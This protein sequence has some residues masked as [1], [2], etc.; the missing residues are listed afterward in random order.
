MLSKDSAVFPYEQEAWNRVGTQPQ[1]SLSAAQQGPRWEVIAL[2]LTCLLL[3]AIRWRL[4]DMP[5]ERDEGEYAYAGQLMLQGIPPYQMAYNMKLPG[6]YAAYASIMAIAGQTDSGVRLGLMF[7]NLLTIFAVYGIGKR[8][9]GSKAGSVAAISYGL[10]SIGPWVHGFA[11]HATHFVVLFA[12]IGTLTLLHA[13]E[14]QRLWEI[15]AAGLLFGVAFLMK[16]PGAAF[17]LF[18]V[19]YLAQRS[20]W[21]GGGFS[22]SARR[23]AVL[24]LGMVLPFVLTC[25]LLWHAG[26]FA[27]F[28]FWTFSYAYQYGTNLGWRGG[29][30]FFSRNFTK[31]ALSA[32][33]LWTLAGIGI[34]SFLWDR[35]AR[36]CA[37][38][39]LGLLFFS[40]IALSAGLYFRPH[41]FI[42]LLPSISLLV[43]LAVN[44]AA[45]FFPHDSIL[46]RC[47]PA[48]AFSIACAATLAEEAKFFFQADPISAS[49][50]VY[51]EDP[52]PECRAIGLYIQRNLPP[53]ATMAMFGSEPQIMFYARR[54][55]V[56]GYLYGY[57]LTEEQK[58]ASI[59][60]RELIGEIESARPD[61]IVQV[62]DWD[63]RPGTDRSVFAWF[64]QYI[65]E[66]Y[67]ML[68]VLRKNDDLQ[69][70]PEDEIRR[71]PGNLEGAILLYVRRRF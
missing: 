18:A 7:V 21:L 25:A 60:Q 44:S 33:P 29:W 61:L 56:T 30:R 52:F 43:G 2:V 63:L 6:T 32:I 62:E 28:W 41:Y 57:S 12:I 14:R 16:Q 35:K 59:M 9:Y 50:Y 20:K 68:E 42:L 54:H 38:F 69:I 24:I 36:V 26:V 39:L 66:S 55:S 46:A 53:S 10:L 8:I 40:G 15:F 49:R 58:Y 45:R 48:L 19:F 5:F 23:L 37:A 47:V 31:A 3:L 27:K 17:G 65:T 70:R 64:S 34:S 71:A 1:T 22:D 67:S 13:L 51:P 11:G 4:R